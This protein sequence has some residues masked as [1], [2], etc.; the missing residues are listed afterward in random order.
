MRADYS[1][2]VFRVGVAREV[3]HPDKLQSPS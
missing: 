2:S 3:D 1:G